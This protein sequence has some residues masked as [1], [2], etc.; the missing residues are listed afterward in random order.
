MNNLALII[1]EEASLYIAK[2]VFLIKKLESF[3][4]GVGLWLENTVCI[5]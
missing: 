3:V 1:Q 5:V 2:C 4:W